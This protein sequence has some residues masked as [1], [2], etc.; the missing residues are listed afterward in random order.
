MSDQERAA[1][2]GETVLELASQR[3]EMASLRLKAQG[4]SDKM[5]AVLAVLPDG[6]TIPLRDVLA[7][8]SSTELMGMLVDLRDTRA[9]IDELAN[10]LK[11]MGLE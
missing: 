10:R 11:E 4:Y 5:K 9:R 1:L 6:L 7:W 2:V 8:P 3:R